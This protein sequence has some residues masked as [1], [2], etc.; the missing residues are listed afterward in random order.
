M[1]RCVFNGSPNIR[2]TVTLAEIY[3]NS[4]EQTGA[5]IFWAISVIANHIIIGDDASNAFAE[6]QS[7]KAPVYIY[8]DTTKNAMRIKKAI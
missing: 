1:A 6:D 7:P 5:R 8:L 3:A 2:I 4:I